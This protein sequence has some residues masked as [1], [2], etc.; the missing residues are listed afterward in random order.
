MRKIYDFRCENQHITEHLVET[1]ETSRRCAC[2]AS[3]TRIISPVRCRLDGSDD[4]F[5]GAHMKW[6]REHEKAGGKA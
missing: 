3:S 2:G 4:G 6:V 1:S 5:P